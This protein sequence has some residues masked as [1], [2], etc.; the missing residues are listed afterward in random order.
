MTI[1]ISGRPIDRV[2][3]FMREY[4]DS[5]DDADI[6]FRIG[7]SEDGAPAVAVSINGSMHCFTSPEARSIARIVEKTLNDLPKDGM[8]T[9]LPNLILGMRAVADKA[10][11]VLPRPR[12]V[13]PV[14]G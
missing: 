14:V 3:R 11:A 5:P 12:R 8:A 10:E 6:D 2:L 13:G 7:H 9:D 1:Y 4:L